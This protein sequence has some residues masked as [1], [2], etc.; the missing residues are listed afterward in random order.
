M[1]SILV[2]QKEVTETSIHL[3]IQKF[4]TNLKQIEEKTVAVVF[5][6]WVNLSF[7]KIFRKV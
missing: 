1:K 5:M 2:L 3:A 4:L 6:G 7:F